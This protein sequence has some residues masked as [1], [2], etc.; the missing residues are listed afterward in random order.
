MSV[1]AIVLLGTVLSR[2]TSA[3]TTQKG[4]GT[5]LNAIDISADHLK[6][7]HEKRSAVFE[8]HIRATFGALR[9]VCAKMSLRY[10]EKG[11]VESL[12][13]WGGV[14]VTTDDGEAKSESAELDVRAFRLVLKGHPSIERGGN[15]L[16]GSQIKVDLKTGKVDVAD[17]RGTFRLKMET[18]P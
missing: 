2:S 4:S 8:G 15:R 11:E 17:A 1:I 16:E 5:S 12:A 13:A 3:Q 14:T 7:D 9:L 10:T 6:V 18:V